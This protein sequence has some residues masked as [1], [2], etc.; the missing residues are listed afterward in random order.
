MADVYNLLDVNPATNFIVDT[1]SRFND[2]IEWLPGRTV[3]LGLRFE[4]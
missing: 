2:V 4:F 3:K 1:G